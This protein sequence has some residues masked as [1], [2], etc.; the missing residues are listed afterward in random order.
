MFKNLATLAVSSA[1]L[2]ASS[3]EAY[4]DTEEIISRQVQAAQD[5]QNGQVPETALLS[6]LGAQLNAQQE[7]GPKPFTWGFDETKFAVMSIKGG[8]F[9][10]DGFHKETGQTGLAY[11]KTHLTP[12]IEAVTGYSDDDSVM[13]SIEDQIHDLED[14]LE[15]A[16]EEESESL[17][18]EIHDLEESTAAMEPELLDSCLSYEPFTN[19]ELLDMGANLD[20]TWADL[21]CDEDGYT[22]KVELEAWAN[23]EVW[24]SYVKQTMESQTSIT[25]TFSSEPESIERRKRTTS[26]YEF[27]EFVLQHIFFTS[28]TLTMDQVESYSVIYIDDNDIYL[29]NIVMTPDVTAEEAEAINT[30]ILTIDDSVD[31]TYVI[32]S[33]D[34]LTTTSIIVDLSGQVYNYMISLA[35]GVTTDEY[36]ATCDGADI[37]EGVD[38][39]I[40]Y[41][42][43]TDATNTTDS[44]S[45][46]YGTCNNKVADL[47]IET[48]TG[49]LVAHSAELNDKAAAASV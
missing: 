21:D 49:E 5:L 47:K 25:V 20:D 15:D 32:S 39:V 34:T 44:I 18:D 12:V 11:Y 1:C 35:N 10:A 16:D 36:F 26:D 19:Q 43:T 42:S 23:G 38:Y 37:V 28:S 17:V 4:L 48:C 33:T 45:S 46:Y 40:E 6:G 3:T 30:E 27:A 29:L 41:E 7:T 2:F 14:E 22:N 13:D 9:N 8:P 24:D 31:G